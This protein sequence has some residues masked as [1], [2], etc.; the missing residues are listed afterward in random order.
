MYPEK[1][2]T[3]GLNPPLTIQ[4]T[5]EEARTKFPK[6]NRNELVKDK[7]GQMKTTSRC[8]VKMVDGQ[9][10]PVNGVELIMKRKSVL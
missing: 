6:H 5:A 9:V 4:Y 10:N 3:E 1:P 2:D 7:D 8:N